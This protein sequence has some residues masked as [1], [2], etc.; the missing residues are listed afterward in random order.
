LRFQQRTE[1]DAADGIVTIRSAAACGF[2]PFNPPV[3]TCSLFCR[4]LG[5]PLPLAV[6]TPTTNH[7]PI[8]GGGIFKFHK[9]LAVRSEQFPLP[10][11]LYVRS[12][13]DIRHSFGILHGKY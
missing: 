2:Q 4:R 13:E 7:S 8:F 11:M 1:H 6:A 3:R 12:T 9:A 10:S 5:Y